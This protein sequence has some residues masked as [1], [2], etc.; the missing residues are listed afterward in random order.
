MKDHGFVSLMKTGRLAYQI[1]SPETVS[2]DV[3]NVF[4]RVRKRIANMLQVCII[5]RSNFTIKKKRKLT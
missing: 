5:S 1:P 2:R 3:K 4:V